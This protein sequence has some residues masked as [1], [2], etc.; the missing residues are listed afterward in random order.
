MF[1]QQ[2]KFCKMEIYSIVHILSTLLHNSTVHSSNVFEIK[3]N[4]WLI[5]VEDSIKK[6]LPSYLVYLISI[7]CHCANYN[8]N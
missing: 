7:K 8:Y 3:G 1:L 2:Q 6:L 4:K 5:I